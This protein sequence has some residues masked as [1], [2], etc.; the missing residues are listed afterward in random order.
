MSSIRGK[1]AKVCRS[2]KKPLSHSEERTGEHRRSRLAVKRIGG[3]YREKALTKR[4]E[5]DARAL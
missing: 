4:C 1:K 3:E 5:V 2:L